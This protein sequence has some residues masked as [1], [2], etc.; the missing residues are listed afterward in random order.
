[1]NSLDLFQECLQHPE[2]LVDEF[3]CHDELII[4]PNPDHPATPVMQTLTEVRERITAAKV[5]LQDE[6]QDAY[7]RCVAHLDQ[8]LTSRSWTLATPCIGNCRPKI[9]SSFWTPCCGPS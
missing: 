4:S 2:R 6:D 5:A 3:Y 1:M 8:M 7:D 9:G